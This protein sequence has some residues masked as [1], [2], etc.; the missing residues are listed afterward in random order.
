MSTLN[1]EAHDAEVEKMVAEFFPSEVM[2]A[3]DENV[4]TKIR[5]AVSHAYWRGNLNVAREI[6]S[7]ELAKQQERRPVAA[8]MASVNRAIAADAEIFERQ[9]APTVLEREVNTAYPWGWSY[10][11]AKMQ[12]QFREFC[13]RSSH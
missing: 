2:H 10:T 5:E 4:R 7:A 8:H 13:R 9:F 12:N 3:L 11:S 1:Q 6:F